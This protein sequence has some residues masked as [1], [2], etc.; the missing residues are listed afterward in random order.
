M[1]RVPVVY[2][3]LLARGDVAQGEEGDLLAGHDPH[4]GVR[5]ARVV[6]VCGLVAAQR[7]VDGEI[8]GEP[9]DLDRVLPWPPTAPAFRAL[10]RPWGW[11]SASATIRYKNLP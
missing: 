2:R 9:D 1:V 11:C 7:A 3:D 6:D 5:L 4:V 8:V 10:Q